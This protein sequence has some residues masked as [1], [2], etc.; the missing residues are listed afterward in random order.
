MN[1]RSPALTLGLPYGQKTVKTSKGTI[2]V[3]NTIRIQ[4]NAEIKRLYKAYLEANGNSDLLMS[5]STM[6]RLLQGLPATRRH[7]MSCVDN[8]LADSQKVRCFGSR[9]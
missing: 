7:S 4:S 8:F 3:P 2:D 9:N 1:F 5:D 6:D